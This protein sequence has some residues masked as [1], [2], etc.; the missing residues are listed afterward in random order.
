MA[1]YDV[2]SPAEPPRFCRPTELCDVFSPAPLTLGLGDRDGDE[3]EEDDDGETE[4]VRALEETRD[5]ARDR[6]RETGDNERVDRDGERDGDDDGDLTS[7]VSSND[8][9]RVFFFLR[10]AMV[11]F[12]LSSIGAA[13]CLIT[14]WA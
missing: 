4:V 3:E 11:F 12:L 14:N 13:Y 6:A 5:K 7:F 2:F 1:L 8:E 9:D 10:A